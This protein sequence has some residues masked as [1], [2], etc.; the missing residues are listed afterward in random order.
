MTD[1]NINPFEF[2]LQL[3][4]RNKLNQKHSNEVLFEEILKIE[5]A[6]NCVKSTVYD[7]PFFLIAPTTISATHEWASK[8]DNYKTLDEAKRNSLFKTGFIPLNR[9]LLA[10]K[11]IIDLFEDLKVKGQNVILDKDYG[12]IILPDDALKK[13]F[14]LGMSELERYGKTYPYLK[15]GLSNI[16]SIGAIRAHSLLNNK[17]DF[18]PI[19]VLIDSREDLNKLISTIKRK[20]NDNKSRF[21]IWFRG[22]NNEHILRE[23]DSDL[24]PFAPWR[25]Y[26][27]PSLVPSIF[28]GA[29][30]IYDDLNDYTGK[31]SE[32][33]ELETALNAHLNIPRYN[34]RNGNDKN[35]KKYFKGTVW[36]DSNSAFTV[37][38][39]IDGNISEFHDYNPVFRALQTSLFLQ[40]YGVPTNILDITKDIDVA[41]FFSQTKN[42][43]GKYK[44]LED[45][46]NSVIYIFLLDPKTDRFIDSSELLEEFGVQ[47]PLR[48]KCGVL[49]GASFMHQNYYSRFISIRIKLSNFI[50]FDRKV[51]EEFLFPSEDQDPVLNHLNNYTKKNSFKHVHAF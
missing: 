46:K 48:Q 12:L 24:L 6:L 23:I 39:V 3:S 38:R 18:S 26:T 7:N 2:F 50:N 33:H 19:D 15:S 37:E 1:N 47:R 32:I 4:R 42:T 27:D 31:L 17:M 10:K 36:E 25:S 11:T 9:K 8:T 30:T 51:N 16:F 29:D 43:N 13:N 20:L 21:Q 41:L 5:N 49:A 35:I 34:L 45:V 22:Q 28:R 14:Y 40:H 44:L